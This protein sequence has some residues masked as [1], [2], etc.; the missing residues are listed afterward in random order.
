M[1]RLYYFDFGWKCVFS[2]ARIEH[3]FIWKSI[4]QEH[5]QK[6]MIEGKRSFTHHGK[7]M[8]HTR[9]N[10]GRK[11]RL[12]LFSCIAFSL[13]FANAAVFQVD[14]SEA[15]LGFRGNQG[16]KEKEQNKNLLCLAGFSK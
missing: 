10:D 1:I 7:F 8:L 3:E 5:V 15:V 13:S 14:A 6:K 11:I 9:W 12:V 2:S 16:I 4:A